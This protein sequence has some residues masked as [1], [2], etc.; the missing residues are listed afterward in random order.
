MSILKVQKLVNL[1]GTSAP[2]VETPD[3]L[4]RSKR[5]ANTEFI[6]NAV[7]NLEFIDNYFTD[8]P[9]LSGP[10]S[11]DKNST[12]TITRENHDPDAVYFTSVTGGTIIDN[13]DGTLSWTLP[14]VLVDTPYYIEEYATTKGYLKSNPATLKVDVL[15]V[16]TIAPVLSG[17]SNGN[18]G[19]T[20]AITI[21]NYDAGAISYTISVNGGSYIRTNAVISWTLPAVET[22]TNYTMGVFVTTGFG[23]SA[24]TNKTVQVLNV[25]VVADTAVQ[26]TDYLA[27]EDTNNGFS[28]I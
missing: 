10:T 7:L 11:G 25:P 4:D 17:P 2:E 23:P 27:V 18:E 26:V 22:D 9:V 1:D 28:H 24:T 20:V 14:D 21:T 12:I 5:I 8:Q 15:Y 3:P 16:P 13:G 19:S 6:Q